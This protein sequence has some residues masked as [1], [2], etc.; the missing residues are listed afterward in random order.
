MK[1]A[2]EAAIR[3][4]SLDGKRALQR[5]CE[6]IGRQLGESPYHATIMTNIKAGRL[7]EALKI[8]RTLEAETS[9]I[10][11]DLSAA[12][13]ARMRAWGDAFRLYHGEIRGRAEAS[14]GSYEH[15][16]TGE[17]WDRAYRRF[18][19][20][21][22]TGTFRAWIHKVFRTAEVDVIRKSG[23]KIAGR[24]K[25]M[26]LSTIADPS[27]LT[28]HQGDGTSTLEHRRSARAFI[29]SLDPDKLTIWTQW[30]ELVEQGA[31]V[32]DASSQLGRLHDKTPKAISQIVTRV[33]SDFTRLYSGYDLSNIVVLWVES[34]EYK[35]G[36]TILITGITVD[37]QMQVVLNRRTEQLSVQAFIRLFEAVRRRRLPVERRILLVIDDSEGLREAIELGFRDHAVIQPCM[38]CLIDRITREVAFDRREWTRKKLLA[39]HS[40]HG[41][42]KARD[43]LI[44]LERALRDSDPGA[45]RI[46]EAELEA[47]LTVKQYGL[48]RT[49][50]QKLMVVE[51]D[52]EANVGT[53]IGWLSDVFVRIR[54][55]RRTR[56]RQVALQRLATLLTYPPS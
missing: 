21:N 54:P 14:A 6:R 51:P 29:G 17:A 37:D 55:H 56:R 19:T 7:M 46:L 23:R 31:S 34:N 2:S 1:I 40:A 12:E 42:Q 8:V 13:S 38:H 25:N 9:K 47:V 22:A 30:F 45:A 10:C 26:E 27:T 20:W 52:D 32:K 4:A 35:H 36:F 33:G 49:L 5:A 16:S 24:I 43:K 18:Y 28:E 44:E 15:E 50:E 39:A 3:T 11:E 48:P 53:S 41:E